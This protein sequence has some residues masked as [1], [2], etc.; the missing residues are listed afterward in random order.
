MSVLETITWIFFLLLASFFNLLN[1]LLYA[2]FS[3][4][5]KIGFS[6]KYYQK[7]DF[8]QFGFHGYPKLSNAEATYCN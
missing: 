2:W 5:D 8:L 3:D 7:F 4:Y 1:N 6:D